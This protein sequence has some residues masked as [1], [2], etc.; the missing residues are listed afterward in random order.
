MEFLMKAETSPSRGNKIIVRAVIRARSAT[1]LAALFA[2][3]ALAGCQATTPPADTPAEDSR[4]AAGQDVPMPALLPIGDVQGHAARSTHLDQQVSIQGVVVGNFAK[5]LQGVFV[6][7]ERDDGDPQTAE[8]I[9]VE[10]DADAQPQLHT[11]DRVRVS[12][13]VAEL[14]DDGASLTTLRETVIEVIGHGDVAPTTLSQAPASSADWERYEGMLLKIDAPLTVSG[15]E[16]LASYGELT[17]SFGA[18]LFQP[19]EVAAPGAAANALAQENARRTLLLDDDRTSK[20]PQNLWFLSKG[21]NAA[22]PVRAGSVLRGVVGVLDQRRGSYRLQ[23]TEKLEVQQAPRPAPPTVPG[24]LRV[25]SLNLLNLFNGD[26]AGGGFPTERGAQ[27]S[28]QYQRQQQKLVASVQALAPDIA[29][30]MEVENDGSGAQSTAAEFAAAL[31]AA[32]PNRDYKL[33]DTGDKLGND[34]IHVAMLYRS[35][36]VTPQGAAASLTGGPF[37]GHSRVPMAQAFRAGAGPVF[38]IAVNHFKSKGCGHDDKQAQGAD[39]DQ[40]DGQSC[41]NA[42]RL[43]SARELQTWLANDPTH[44]H[45]KLQLIVGDLN[46]YAQEDPLRLLRA[47]GWQDAFA[48]AKVAQP[49]SFVFDGQAGRLDHALL[50]PALSKRLR[51]AA[52]WHNNSDEAEFFDYHL[53]GAA[54]P[55]RASDHDPIL[56]GFDLGR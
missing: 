23:L 38:V 42:T 30:L 28:E 31:N 43:E 22:E 54:G 6:Q 24:D 50:S 56:L 2:M 25:A 52:E 27:T 10:R 47:A 5:E 53:D 32:G 35:S 13:R 4:G 20:D 37:A 9:F 46:A 15:N 33:I 49:Y 34:A 39:A 7:S 36:R 26:G 45:S 19:T 8:G 21:L 17:A 40:H 14:G 1:A 12:G 11:G 44:A 18:R 16:G 41:W 55:Y 51:G 3:A 29:A 48:L